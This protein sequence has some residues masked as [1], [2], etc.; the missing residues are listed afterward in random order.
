[1]ANFQCLSPFAVLLFSK[2][3]KII[4]NENRLITIL[5]PQTT[6]VDNLKQR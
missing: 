2:T 4:P 5:F 6:K 3:L 1:M